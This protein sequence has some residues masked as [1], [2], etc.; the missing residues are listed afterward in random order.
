MKKSEKKSVGRPK[1][2]EI[3]KKPQK[4]II[5]DFAGIVPKARFINTG[6]VLF[7]GSD[8]DKAYKA[9][10]RGLIEYKKK[11]RIKLEGAA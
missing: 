9:M 8:L 2:K 7:R 3:K 10:R 1:K 4:A 11:M 5:I 6:D